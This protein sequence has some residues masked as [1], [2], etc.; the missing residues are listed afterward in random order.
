MLKIA[1]IGAGLW[2]QEH[3]RIFSNE[4]DVQITGICDLNIDR[5]REFAQ[6]YGVAD[7]NVYTDYKQMLT[8]ADCDAV[9]IVTPDFLHTEIACDCAN[10]KKHMLIEKPLA[11]KK[12]DVY[13]ILDAVE[14]NNVR[15]MVDMHNRWSPPFQNVKS[16]LAEGSMGRPINA[17]FRLNDVKSVATNMLSWA[18]KSS[19]L[20]FL[21]SHT[22]DTLN[23]LLDSFPAEVYARSSKG[24]LASLG[25][26][27]VDV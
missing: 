16:I 9:S 13:A 8:D 27:V 11:T 14:K 17:Y 7:K 3:G 2:A 22:V 20:W 10:A 4:K 19:I 6:K 21:G 25:V 24:V 1:I 12:E 5:A 18:A 15:V 26:D 23:W